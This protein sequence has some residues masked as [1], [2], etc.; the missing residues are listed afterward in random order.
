MIPPQERGN[1]FLVKGVPAPDRVGGDGDESR[2]RMCQCMLLRE[3]SFLITLLPTPIKWLCNVSAAWTDS[4]QKEK[5]KKGFFLSHLP[6]SKRENCL[7]PCLFALL[8]LISC[9]VCFSLPHCIFPRLRRPWTLWLLCF[10]Q[11]LGALR[12]VSELSVFGVGRK[13]NGSSWW[14]AVW[15]QP[16]PLETTS[17]HS[18]GDNSPGHDKT[19]PQPPNAPGSAGTPHGACRT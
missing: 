9:S 4:N 16:A 2:S 19:A 17:G 5:Q 10:R 11:W 1:F 18:A 3:I 13:K 14:D 15:Q 7:S 12:E 6:A 8:S